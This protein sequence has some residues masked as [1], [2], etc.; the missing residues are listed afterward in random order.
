MSTTQE[1]PSAPNPP[2]ENKNQ[3]R[4]TVVTLSGNYSDTYNRHQKLDHVVSTTL[5]ELG[6]QPPPGEVWILT[7]NGDILDQ[8]RTI[9]SYQL[10]DGAVLQLAAKEGGGG[11][12]W[13]R[14]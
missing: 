2:P 7:Y 8:S 9:E 11:G 13:T 14:T 3:V 6:V 4:L 5:K 1:K 12:E 10:P